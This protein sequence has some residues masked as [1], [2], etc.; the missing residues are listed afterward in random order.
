M[1]GRSESSRTGEPPKFFVAAFLDITET[2]FREIVAGAAHY[3]REVGDWQFHVEPH[4]PSMPSAVRRWR[5]HGIIASLHDPEIAAAVAAS[6]VPV[7]EVG[8]SGVG[9]AA[10]IP[11]VDTDD[12]RVAAMAFDHL[13][14]RGLTN[15]GY[16]G[17]APTPA[18]RWAVRRGDAFLACAAAA[19][20]PCARLHAPEPPADADQAARQLQEW[21]AGLP[22][23][24]GIMASSDL[25]GRQVL[26][27]CRTMRLRVPYDVS[28]IGVDND[29]L[30]CELAAPPLTSIEQAA[31]PIGYEAAKLLDMMLCPRRFAGPGQQPAVPPRIAIPPAGIVARAS[32]DTLAIV[33]PAVARIMQIVRDRGCSGLTTQEMV[34]AAGLPRWKLEKRFREVVGHSIHDEVVRVRLAEARRLVRSS[35][36]PLKIVAARS[37]FHSVAYMTTIFRRKFG[38]TPARY[39]RLERDSVLRD[40][41]P[42]DKATS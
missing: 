9:E 17:A 5:G 13:R 11:L 25:H 2:F 16:Y 27:A 12:E 20:H 34:D 24:V 15:F 41:A 6:G 7:V 38:T 31:R 33:D 3:A 10:G 35:D 22:K 39:R 1:D 40:S 30:E 32:T 42:D 8:T 21:I 36:L 28:V 23:P 18:T 37:G 14:E 19:G 4:S 29:E 26:T